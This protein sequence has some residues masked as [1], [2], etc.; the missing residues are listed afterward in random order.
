MVE[1][2]HVG[3]DGRNGCSAE[4]I[5]QPGILKQWKS[6]NR[7]NTV[8]SDAIKHLMHQVVLFFKDVCTNIPLITI[9][10]QDLASEAAMPLAY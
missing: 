3:V 7:C 5:V 9:V 6:R 1:D 8:Y 2:G 10:M 4:G